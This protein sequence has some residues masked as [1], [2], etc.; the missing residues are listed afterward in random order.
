VFVPQS[1][2]DYGQAT[3]MWQENLDKYDTIVSKIN[4]DTRIFISTYPNSDYI[5]LF[6]SYEREITDW[7]GGLGFNVGYSAT[8]G[9]FSDYFNHNVTPDI[10]VVLLYKKYVMDLGFSSVLGKN[11]EE[12][13]NSDGFILPKDTSISANNL[14][15]SL[16]YTFFEHKRVEVVPMAGIGTTWVRVA[17]P[18]GR[19]EDPELKEFNYWYGLTAFFG[20]ATDIRFGPIRRMPGQNF[21]YPSIT[22]M[23]ISYKFSYN[24]LKQ[25]IP[26]FYDGNFHTIS[27]GFR[28][29]GKGIRQVKYN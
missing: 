19:K 4:T 22:T 5:D 17:S 10:Y 14:Y 26:T 20:I 28:I 7:G 9:G 2:F 15:L 23:R 25:D 29:A 24:T 11:R 27:A 13:V 8:T 1:N 18:N 16:G 3:T 21:N 6:E 12:I